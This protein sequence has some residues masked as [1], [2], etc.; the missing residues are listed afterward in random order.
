M[1][2]PP[3]VHNIH[4]LGSRKKIP[5]GWP[6]TYYTDGSTDLLREA[7]GPERVQLRLEG[8]STSTF[9]GKF[10]ATCDLPEVLRAPYPPPPLDPRMTSV[11]SESLGEYVHLCILIPYVDV[12]MIKR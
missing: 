3:I 9:L 10:I 5:P 6:F 2:I 12:L 4:A 11:N 7:I 1:K 8:V